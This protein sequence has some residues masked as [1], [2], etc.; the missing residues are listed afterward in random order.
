MICTFFG[1]KNSPDSIGKK[2]K[3]Y[4]IELINSGVKKFY[5]GNNGNFDYLVQ[6]LLKELS[7]CFK[8]EYDI[9]LSR[10]DEK[11]MI[12][13][14]KFSLFP[15]ELENVPPRFA[16]SRRN[17]WMI[18][19][20]DIAVVYVENSLTNSYKWLERAK[21]LGLQVFNIYEE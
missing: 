17:E 1:H 19:K 5:V 18:K 8:F 2:L 21:K 7:A 14:W 4:I 20:S 11:T 13:D 15:E 6:S 16:I 10:I 3:A 9:V 12:N